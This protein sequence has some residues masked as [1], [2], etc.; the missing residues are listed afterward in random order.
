MSKDANHISL[1][2][3]YAVI[4]AGGIGARFWPKSRETKP[5]QYLSLVDGG[6]L[7]QNTAERL[8]ELVDKERIFIVTTQ[9]Q[10]NILSEQIDW[11]P[12][13]HIL[14]EPMG[15]N[16]APAIGLAAL[17]LYKQDP[18]SI[19]VIAPADHRI[20]RTHEYLD[21][22]KTAI[23]VVKDDP[24]ALVTLGISPSYPA[25]GYGYIEADSALEQTKV[26][27][28]NR[29]TEKPPLETAKFFC[30]KGTYY[31]NSG[32]FIW[33]TRTILDRIQRFMPE[34]HQGL[35]TIRAAMDSPDYQ[36]TLYDVYDSLQGQSI[37]YGVMEKSNAHVYMVQ[38]D[39][40]W[41]DLGTW[42]EVYNNS[43]KDENGNVIKGNPLLKQV[44][45]SYIE[46]HDRTV[47]LIGVSDLVVVDEPDALLICNL[48]FS[49][50]VRWV[51]NQL[52]PN[53]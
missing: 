51:T 49:Q 22:L 52:D 19:L 12:E 20:A 15:K 24:K 31:W 4:L 37:D 1:P 10:Q 21:C 30:D 45:N 40:G 7:I 46:V 32:I 39:F 5:K 33:K 27:S 26:Y 47:S 6:T 3:V 53:K 50:D 42:Q 29:F 16:T 9:S 36:N 41:S 35:E 2:H 34:L 8:R 17:Y 23:R 14:H 44:K 13:E 43:P 25:T 28:V 48:D 18:E 11:V 38:S